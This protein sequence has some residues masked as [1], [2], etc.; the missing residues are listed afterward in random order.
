[1]HMNKLYSCCK[2]VWLQ[3]PNKDQLTEY[4]ESKKM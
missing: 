2:N 4:C 1:M 3:T